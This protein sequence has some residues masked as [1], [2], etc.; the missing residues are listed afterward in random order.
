MV[1]FLWH[2]YMVHPTTLMTS[3]KILELNWCLLLINIS[4]GDNECWNLTHFVAQSWEIPKQ[5]VLDGFSTTLLVYSG[6]HQSK[7]ECSSCPLLNNRVVGKRVLWIHTGARIHVFLYDLWCTIVVWRDSKSEF[8][9]HL[10][11]STNTTHQAR[12][13]HFAL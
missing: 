6:A 13:N 10:V 5:H 11:I 3:L 8:F 1:A 4:C 12:Q 7:Y 2:E 9:L